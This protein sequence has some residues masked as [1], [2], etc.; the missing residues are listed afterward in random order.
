MIPLMSLI[1]MM[2]DFVAVIISICWVA[3]SFVGFLP[4]MGWHK[5]VNGDVECYFLKVMDY[6]Y[7]VFLYVVTIMTPALLLA[8][9]YA[10]IYSVVLKQ[11]SIYYF[12]SPKIF[13]VNLSASVPPI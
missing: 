1:Y 7:L 9:F 4:L 11:V 8:A 5:V 12:T 10:H 13:Q 3:G 6:N 2:W